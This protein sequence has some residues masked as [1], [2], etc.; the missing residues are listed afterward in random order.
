MK[1]INQL[2]KI[3]KSFGNMNLQP[4]AAPIDFMVTHCFSGIDFNI[5]KMF[6][7]ILTKKCILI[8]FLLFDKK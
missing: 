1:C 5:F 3:N 8:Y 2:N 6:L 4:A 7:K